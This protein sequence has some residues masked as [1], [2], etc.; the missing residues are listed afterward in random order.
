MTRPRIA[1]LGAG[2]WGRNHVRTLSSMPS[3]TLSAVCDPDPA[4]RRE[5]ESA[6]SGVMVTEGVED[7]LRNADAVVIAA[8]ANLHA[9]L[10][11]QVIDRGLPVLIEKPMTL[12]VADAE[13]I[14]AKAET[15]GVPVVVGHVLLFHPV[16]ERLR[17]LIAAG[18]LGDVY[19]LYGRRVNLGRVRPDENALWSFGPHDVSITMEL[20]GERPV[21]V[22]AHGR[23]FLQPDIE[24]V[25]FFT[26]EFA[27]GI[28]AQ[29]Q[30]SWLD[31][32][33]ERQLTV[34]GSR[35]MV[36]FDDMQAREKL[37]IFDRGIDRPPEYGSY[38]ESLAIR[39]GDI[40]IPRVA[41]TEPLRAELSHFV[42]VV[43]DGVTPRVSAHDGLQVVRVL[44]AAS[45]S[46][47]SGGPLVS[48]T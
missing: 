22:A 5:V 20:L 32:H 34:V 45:S 30:M 29:I 4:R 11:A 31:P 37:T 10:A 12:T 39:E 2:N 15:A 33:K 46:L 35:R 41:N 18:E 48:L 47:K 16:I 17:E 1:V 13:A 21:R 9:S 23:A 43:R 24:D 28:L 44:A 14:V 6:Y 19:Y 7:A 38:G 25:V 8:P 27:S 3:V 42:D 36:V 26:M 40:L